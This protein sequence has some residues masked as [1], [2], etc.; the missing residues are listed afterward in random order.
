MVVTVV[1]W[2]LPLLVGLMLT[3]QRAAP[4]RPPAPPQTKGAPHVTIG[5]ESHIVPPTPSYHPQYGDTYHYTVEWRLWDAG[6]ATLR[7]GP[8]GPEQHIFGNADSSGF[9]AVLYPVHDRF[10]A[11]FDPRTFCSTSVSK[12][13]E[14]GFHKRDT[15]IRFDYP[16]RRSVLDETNLKSKELKHT[17]REIPS[18]VTD[19]V[20]GI[21]YIG[22]LPLAA[23]A[24]YTFPLNDGGETVDVKAHVEAREEIKTDAGSFKTIR[25]APEAT[26]GVVKERGHVWI[27][28]TD[29]DRRIPVQIRARMFWGTLTLKLQRIEQA[30]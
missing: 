25:V 30:Q 1:R 16:R 15:L 19:V 26:A 24:S 29:D 3:G 13:T 27:W 23:D 4:A 5:P 10:Q 21:F 9:V 8:Q 18:C 12:H 2:W 28:Y 17:E 11:I 6:T 20:S 22:S 14:E 7:I